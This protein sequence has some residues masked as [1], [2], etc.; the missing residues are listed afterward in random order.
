MTC[1]FALALAVG[2]PQTPG[3]LPPAPPAASAFD[4]NWTV[5]YAE[6]LGRPITMA[7]SLAIRGGT[8]TI[9]LGQPVTYRLDVGPGHSVQA[10]PAAASVPGAATPP[11]P[12]VPAVP[13]PATPPVGPG[14]TAVTAPGASG[15]GSGES[16]SPGLGP[17]T[18]RTTGTAPA[19]SP[20]PTAS[21]AGG[22]G[23][24]VATAPGAPTPATPPVGARRSATVP[25]SLDGT[26]I[27]SQEYLV[28]SMSPTGATA[29]GAS[30]GTA[31]TADVTPGGRVA[32][33]GAAPGPNA[34][35][36]GIRQDAFV[37]ILRRAPAR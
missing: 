32:A 19:T 16:T 31:P 15:V 27:L 33:P 28:L 5:V 30:P 34:A 20:P 13:P 29:L 24:G 21:S 35:G 36:G 7:P 23:G 4:G 11:V 2:A 22:P 25:G 9:N 3:T 12:P 8:V 14:P 26:F 17:K 18:G 1:L 10:I 6:N 37:L